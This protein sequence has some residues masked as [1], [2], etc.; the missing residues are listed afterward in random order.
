VTRLELNGV[1]AMAV[2]PSAPS[3]DVRELGN[4]SSRR[5]P[6]QGGLEDARGGALALPPWVRSLPGVDG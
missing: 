2:S 6:D 1:I 3:G 5:W 4:T